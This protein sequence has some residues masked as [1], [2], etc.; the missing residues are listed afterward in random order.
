RQQRQRIGRRVAIGVSHVTFERLEGQRLGRESR[1]YTTLPLIVMTLIAAGPVKDLL[2]LG[3]R[4][5]SLGNLRA[6]QG[7]RQD[8]PV[9]AHGSPI[10]AAKRY[11]LAPARRA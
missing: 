7:A 6:G 2:A 4:W 9:R 8:D 1:P 5:R 11:R 10:S 3:D